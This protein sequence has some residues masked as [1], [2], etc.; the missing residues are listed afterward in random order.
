MDSV[1]PEVR[2]RI[3][4][5][6]KGRDTAPELALRRALHRMG[7]RYRVCDRRFPGSPDVAFPTER[8]AVFVDG[9]FWRGRAG[10]PKT[11]TAWWRAKFR[12]NRARD[13]RTDRCLKAAGWLVVRIG[14]R[15]RPDP[16]AVERSAAMV[17]TAVLARREL[18]PRIAAALRASR[19]AGVPRRNGY[20]P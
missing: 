17:G 11:R 19:S 15:G 20:R 8:V 2:S 7:F 10:I 9:A 4:R 18:L 13:R 1:T 12:K 3:M 6:I 5:A 16:E 14:S